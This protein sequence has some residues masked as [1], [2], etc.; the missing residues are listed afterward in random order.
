[1]TKDEF[2]K[3]WKRGWQEIYCDGT[4]AY[5]FTEEQMLNDLDRVIFMAVCGWKDFVDAEVNR[6]VDLVEWQRQ[7]AREILKRKSGA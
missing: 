7:E 3:K 5:F 1:M 2:C 6:S 4:E